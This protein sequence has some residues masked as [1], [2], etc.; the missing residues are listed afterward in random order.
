MSAARSAHRR[1]RRRHA[2]GVLRSRTSQLVVTSPSSAVTVISGRVVDAVTGHPVRGAT[3]KVTGV[4]G[5]TPGSFTGND[6]RFQFSDAPIGRLELNA[7]K[8]GFHPGS[9]GQRRPGGEGTGLDVVAGRPINDIEIRIWPM[10]RISGRVVDEFDQPL[11][12]VTVSCAPGRRDVGRRLAARHRADD[13]RQRRGLR[14]RETIRR[15]LHRRRL[16]RVQER[17]RRRL[18]RETAAPDAARVRR[19]HHSLSADAGFDANRVVAA[20]ESHAVSDRRETASGDRPR[21]PDLRIHVGVLPGDAAVVASR[22]D[23]RRPWR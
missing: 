15:R 21:R 18:L 6:G 14:L 7:T 9:L 11:A 17:P 19:A 2:A 22:A 16:A 4:R 8:I 10:S 5:Y 12:G 1:L 3:V 20:A 23:R 13:D